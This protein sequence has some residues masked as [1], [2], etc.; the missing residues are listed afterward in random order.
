MFG[1]RAWP[2]P[3]RI[4][5]KSSRPRPPCR[6]KTPKDRSDRGR[7]VHPDQTCHLIHSLSPYRID[8]T[9]VRPPLGSLYRRYRHHLLGSRQVAGHGRQQYVVCVAGLLKRGLGSGVLAI[10]ERDEMRRGWNG[11]GIDHKGCS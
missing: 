11:S 2:T 10:V 1:L 9:A 5:P 6:I 4:P 7:L 3:V 8:H